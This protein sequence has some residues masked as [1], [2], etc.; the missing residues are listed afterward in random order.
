M[1]HLSFFLV[2]VTVANLAVLA[3]PAGTGTP[4]AFPAAQ[5]LQPHSC[6]VTTPNG[7]VAGSSELNEKSH[8]NALLSVGP[9]GLWPN[10]TVV[11]KPGGAG[12]QTQEGALGMK[13]RL[14]LGLLISSCLTVVQ[15]H[16]QK[17]DP[18]KDT[19]HMTTGGNERLRPQGPA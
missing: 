5:A 18:C 10:G 8:V 11:F 3:M 4:A 9:F 6:H 17:P 7:I 13:F 19:S 1:K 14:M 16:K 12:F 2:L 15:T